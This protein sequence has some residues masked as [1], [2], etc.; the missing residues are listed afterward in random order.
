VYD[1]SI[2]NTTDKKLT[3]QQNI[4]FFLNDLS[5]LLLPRIKAKFSLFPFDKK[6]K[7]IY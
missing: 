1:I 4:N 3:Q 6:I 7:R 2:N 5:L